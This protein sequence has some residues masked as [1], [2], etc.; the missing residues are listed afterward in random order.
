[1]PIAFRCAAIGQPDDVAGGPWRFLA[2]DD[3]RHV[4]GVDWLIDGGPNLAELGKCARRARLS[5]VGLERRRGRMKHVVDG[6][7]A[8][9]KRKLV[10]TSARSRPA[11]RRLGRAQSIAKG[12][13]FPVRAAV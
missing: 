9:S 8:V 13:F 2:S 5:A 3:A 1:L 6:I 10:K 4:T 11:V 12:R 7:R